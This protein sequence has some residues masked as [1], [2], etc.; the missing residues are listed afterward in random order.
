MYHDLPK[1]R[2]VRIFRNGRSRAV[3]IPSEFDL[4]GDEVVLRQEKDGLITIQPLERRLTPREVVEWLRSQP[5]VK[6][7]FPDIDDS[8]LLPLDDVKL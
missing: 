7:E 8:D 6:E 2:T 3:R 1:E 4:P 5:P